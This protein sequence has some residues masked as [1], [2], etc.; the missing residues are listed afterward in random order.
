M[1]PLQSLGAW[2]GPGTSLFCRPPSAA[3]RCKCWTCSRAT[4]L[5][6]RPTRAGRQSAR[7]ADGGGW[8]GGLGIHCKLGRAR[9]LEWFAATRRPHKASGRWWVTR[10]PTCTRSAGRPGV[11]CYCETAR[12]VVGEAEAGGAT[13]QRRPLQP[14]HAGTRSMGL[15]RDLGIYLEDV[16]PAGQL[17]C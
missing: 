15:R 1:P 3:G 17:R 8:A 6:L 13:G 14:R 11:S 7:G 10:R 16:A 9:R 5:R 2:P 12:Y 4:G